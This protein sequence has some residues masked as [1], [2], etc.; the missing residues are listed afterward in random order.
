MAAIKEL[1]IGFIILLIILIA[2]TIVVSPEFGYSLLVL[3]II[4]GII[5]LIDYLLSRL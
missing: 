1:V 2:V 5:K 4:L 3:L